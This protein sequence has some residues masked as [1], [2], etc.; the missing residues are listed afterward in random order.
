[1][2]FEGD[3]VIRTWWVND[4]GPRDT[5]H[6]DATIALPKAGY[7][8]EPVYEAPMGIDV[9]YLVLAETGGSGTCGGCGAA[10]S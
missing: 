2:A 10:G 1:M 3:R 9:S 6:Y 8:K 7:G 5:F 4:C